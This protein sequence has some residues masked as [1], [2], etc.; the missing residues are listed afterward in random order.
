MSLHKKT[1]KMIWGNYRRLTLAVITCCV[2]GGCA[3]TSA[4]T[5][6]EQRASLDTLL[7]QADGELA[8]GK[9]EQAIALLN[10]AAKEN[11]TSM[12]PWLK[13]SN[14][15]FNSG[16]Y[17]SAILTSNE[18]LKRESENQEAKS[19]LVV[20]GLRVAAGAI[21]GLVQQNQV[22]FSARTEAENLTK[23]LRTALGEK[24]L[25]PG[26][27]AENAPP[28]PAAPPPSHRRHAAAPRR[29]SQPRAETAAASSASASPTVSASSSGSDPFK[30]L[31]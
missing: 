19:I 21:T 9:S 11:P 1:K 4:P 8:K 10:Q 22:N 20:A 26:A 15:W 12:V 25:V 14:I 3:T 6:A 7:K 27:G 29:V 17:P 31:K 2:I 18:V 28:P 13:M 30:S 24:V 16:N 5:E 23:A